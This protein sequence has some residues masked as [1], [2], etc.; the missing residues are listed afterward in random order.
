MLEA[1][2][3]V[4]EA[5]QQRAIRMTSGLSGSYEEKL[6]QVGLT[7]LSERRI[8]GDLIQTYKILHQVDDLPSST[9][10]KFADAHNYPTRLAEVTYTTLNLANPEPAN[11][12][13]RRNFFSHRVVDPWNAL[14]SE[15]KFATSV[16]NFKN[17]YD[18]YKQ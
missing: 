14:P 2:I 4:L 3:K 10:F 17:T 1:D 8:R 6:R 9:F 5:V 15:V 13:F 16:N 18:S 12:D 7:N 11:Y